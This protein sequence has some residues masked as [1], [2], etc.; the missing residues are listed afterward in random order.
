MARVRS[1]ET[2][3]E[4]LARAPMRIGNSSYVLTDA[5]RFQNLATVRTGAE[6]EDETG[7]DELAE[8]ELAS[9]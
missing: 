9:S 1:P 5:G 6:D 2:V 8:A 3:G 4:V 7:D